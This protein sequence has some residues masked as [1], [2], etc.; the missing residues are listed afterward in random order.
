MLGSPSWPSRG[1]PSSGRR[2]RFFSRWCAAGISTSARIPRSRFSSCSR[3]CRATA[4]REKEIA[5]D[6]KLAKSTVS[7]T[8]IDLQAGG[9][10]KEMQ[11]EWSVTQKWDNARHEFWHELAG[12]TRERQTTRGRRSR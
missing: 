3:G 7:R 5:T 2:R 11:G 4:L 8:L 1:G 12:L 10:V 9:W 6:L